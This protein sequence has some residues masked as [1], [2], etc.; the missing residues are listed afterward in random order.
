M[1]RLGGLGAAGLL[2][3]WLVAPPAA[4]AIAPTG[5]SAAA[6]GELRGLGELRRGSLDGEAGG[7][8]RGASALTAATFAQ[9]F[10]PESCAACYL[11]GAGAPLLFIE[12]RPDGLG[13]NVEGLLYSMAI[14]AKHGYNFGGAVHYRHRSHGLN[15][16]QAT[17][18]FF[19][20]TVNSMFSTDVPKFDKEVGTL[21]DIVAYQKNRKWAEINRTAYV[22]FTATEPGS[23]IGAS[24]R[25]SYLNP[26]FLEV[27]R[28]Q[29]RPGFLKVANRSG[30]ARRAGHPLVAMHVRRG[31]VDH[32]KGP[33]N[34]LSYR[35]GNQ[36]RERWTPNEW[37]Y[38]QVE[39]IAGRLRGA[40]VHAWSSLENKEG[41]PQPRF[42]KAWF[43]GFRERGVQMH[44][45]T[46]EI[47]AWALMATADVFIMAKSSFSWVPAVLNPSCV[48]YQPWGIKT[49]MR[50][51][52]SFTAAP[53]PDGPT[54]ADLSACLAKVHLA[55][56]PEA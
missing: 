4:R 42:D 27:L 31:D 1:P 53:Y 10:N 41:E 45:D 56:L 39:R 6:A 36:N 23:K 8:L 25:D 38:E 35:S 7:L 17:A 21:L 55:E 44:I 48:L 20:V 14:A 2:A 18:D 30:I 5:S 34:P 37:Y 12:G 46:D 43:G 9:R 40:D 13:N 47:E 33:Q 52:Q 49:E 16:A 51:V 24:F 15:V 54:E 28:S 3:A 11:N 22:L 19:G 50:P 26:E 29:L 32:A